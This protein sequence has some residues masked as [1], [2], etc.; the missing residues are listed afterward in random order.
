MKRTQ[1]QLPELHYEEAKRIADLNEWSISEVLRRGLE[2]I[3][4]SYPNFKSKDDHWKV[5]TQ[6][7]LGEFLVSHDKWRDILAEDEEGGLR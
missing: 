1:I 3:V 6:S 4:K 7:G 2:K 5:P